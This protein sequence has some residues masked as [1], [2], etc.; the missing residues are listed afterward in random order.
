M[1]HFRTSFLVSLLLLSILCCRTL[2]DQE[3]A[4]EERD[5]DTG[6]I[7]VGTPKVYDDAVL[8]ELLVAAQARLATLQVIDQTGIAARLGGL[9]G[10]NQQFSSLTFNALGPPTPAV[11]T[12]ANSPTQTTVQGTTTTTTTGSTPVVTNTAS[13]TSG[14]AVENSTTT[15]PQFN[16]TIPTPTAA[17]TT[18]P[19]T[20][21]GVSAS[22]LLNE[23]VQLTYEIANLRLLLE[24]SLSDQILVTK[25][26]E[27]FVKP[28]VTVGFPIS[29]TPSRSFRNG[30][31]VVEA[32][33]YTT[34]DVE[35]ISGG[36]VAP[37][38]TAILP[39]EKTYNVAA[40]TDRSTSLG[41]GIVTQ[42]ASVGGSFLSGRRTFY[43]VKDQDTVATTFKPATA[44]PRTGFGWH[45]KPVL[46]Q[47]IVQAG[48]RQTFVQL[49]F[50]STEGTGTFGKVHLRTYWRNYDPA[51]GTLRGVVPG[52]LKEYDEEISIPRFDMKQDLADFVVENDAEDLGNGTMAV[53]LAGRFLKGTYVRAGTTVLQAGSG[54][55]NDTLGLRFVAPLGEI[56][57]GVKLITR[58]GTETPVI[59]DF[60]DIE[61][62]TPSIMS[63]SVTVLDDANSRVTITT[64][65]PEIADLPPLVLV[66]GG[67][68]FGYA[69]TPIERS[70]DRSC[71]ETLTAVVPTALLA[72]N[73]EVT[74]KPLLVDSRYFVTD[75]LI[76]AD[77]QTERLMLVSQDASDLGYLLY[78]TGLD[79]MKVIVPANTALDPVGTGVESDR[80]RF[81]G[82]DVAEAKTFKQ[83][84]VQRDGERPF[85]VP[86]PAL[87]EPAKI[88]PK[89][90]ERITVNADEAVIVG[91]GLKDVVKIKALG[92]DLVDLVMDGK[93]LRV[94][95]LAAAGI[96]STARTVDC[97]LLTNTDTL[98]TIQL[99]IVTSKVESIAK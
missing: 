83:L 65:P 30:V 63:K 11:T 89:F 90:V 98:G 95:G 18:L 62:K 20:G 91:D 35:D 21:F 75:R 82:L 88:A 76:S 33:V 52:S 48:L 79:K 14:A 47:D 22:D 74:V 87:T 59:E 39:R 40:I 94:R 44:G 68:V 19:T 72:A 42:V 49:S 67:K 16:A 54:L 93:K 13:T 9:S 64:A 2:S 55:V 8:Q 26:S 1:H 15:V 69:D 66:V 17:A 43:I 51:S 4:L 56:A 29:I 6:G 24:G 45:F 38:L 84:I 27:K 23:E 85:G 57:R 73:R 92:R 10:A 3:R 5:H 34:T 32:E 53:H 61:D 60:D 99:E 70:V 50:P 28:R 25:S 58:D 77:A 37:S 31:A 71:A 97:T 36:K 96:T 78:G 7:A 86:I 46:G 80:V 12:T 81:V 41:A